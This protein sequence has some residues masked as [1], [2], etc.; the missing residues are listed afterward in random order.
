M[1]ASRARVFPTIGMVFIL[2]TFTAA[3]FCLYIKTLWVKDVK[4]KNTNVVYARDD[5][6]A[7][8]VDQNGELCCA[9]LR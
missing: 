6:R 9:A 5:T 4:K 7:R 3:S 2:Q 8:V 1:A